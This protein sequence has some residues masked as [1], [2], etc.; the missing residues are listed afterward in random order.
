MKVSDIKHECPHCGYL[1]DAATA[2]DLNDETEPKTGD[3][4]VC[5]DCGEVCVF[6]D[7][8]HLRKPTDS[9]LL[10]IAGTPGLVMAALVAR[11]CHQ[12]KTEKGVDPDDLQR[13]REL[14][15]RECLT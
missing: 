3:M 15:A 1:L 4:S 14:R 5:I 7:H 10:E 6:T 13:Y 2:C 11:M 8:L 12:Q 9:E